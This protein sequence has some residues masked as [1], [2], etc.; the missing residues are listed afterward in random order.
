VDNFVGNTG[1]SPAA[2]SIYA[3]LQQMLHKVAFVNLLLN[4]S[5]TIDKKQ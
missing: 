3:A 5:L 1:S 2:A 4:Q